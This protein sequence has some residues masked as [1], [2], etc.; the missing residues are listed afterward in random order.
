MVY[1][2]GLWIDATGA[3]TVLS[4]HQERLQRSSI[5][6]TTVV[7]TKPGSGVLPDSRYFSKARDP[8]GEVIIILFRYEL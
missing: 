1:W 4:G 5:L 2:V 7:L 6:P 3:V 8:S